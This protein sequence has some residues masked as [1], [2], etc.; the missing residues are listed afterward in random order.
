MMMLGQERSRIIHSEP[1]T[2]MDRSP[3]MPVRRSDGDYRNDGGF[4]EPSLPSYLPLVSD[5]DQE[6]TA[7]RRVRFAATTYGDVIDIV[8]SERPSKY[9]SRPRGSGDAAVY[10]SGPRDFML[11]R[12]VDLSPRKL[13]DQVLKVYDEHYQ[14]MSSRKKPNLIECDPGSYGALLRQVERR[15]RSSESSSSCKSRRLTTKR[16]LPVEGRGRD[17]SLS[18]ASLPYSRQRPFHHDKMAP[19]SKQ[20]LPSIGKDVPP[21][22]PSPG[23]RLGQG[24]DH[25][26]CFQ[27]QSKKTRPLDLL[28]DENPVR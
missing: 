28:G 17:V 15:G 16:Q 21:V 19:V 4:N 23:W 11:S 9:N 18:P 20:S 22:A 2:A 24:E 8:V 3:R 26:S 12:R 7:Q 5:D 6:K 27:F 10:T 1:T 13:P 14:D 25:G